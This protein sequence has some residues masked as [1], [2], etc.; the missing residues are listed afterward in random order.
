M[1]TDFRILAWRMLWT[2]EPSG[3]P[4]VELQRVG[5]R[6]C[7]CTC[8]LTHVIE[9]PSETRNLLSEE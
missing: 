2:E 1:A 8:L 9:K 4:S 3:L 7:I 5:Y 6:V